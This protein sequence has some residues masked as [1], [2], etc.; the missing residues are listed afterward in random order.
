M[1]N[2][3]HEES[4][5]IEANDLTWDDVNTGSY[6]KLEKD[7]AKILLLVNWKLQKIERFKDD[8]GNVK[9]QIEFSADVLS[10]DGKPCQKV[11]TTTSVNALAGL[12]EVFAYKDSKKAVMIRIKKIGEGVKTV[13]DVEEVRLQ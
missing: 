5:I 2:E 6:V 7:K 8:K 11:F 12:K 10:E 4:R 1:N 3:I 13:Y 9:Q